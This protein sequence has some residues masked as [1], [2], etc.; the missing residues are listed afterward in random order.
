MALASSAL[1]DASERA[2]GSSRHTVAANAHLVSFVHQVHHFLLKFNA[3]LEKARLCFVQPARLDHFLL[4]LVHT[5]LGDL[6]ASLDFHQM[7]LELRRYL[8]NRVITVLKALNANVQKAHLGP[9]S[10]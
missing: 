3:D 1:Q 2:L 4:Q 8:V 6:S 9:I 10:H 5:L 7:Q